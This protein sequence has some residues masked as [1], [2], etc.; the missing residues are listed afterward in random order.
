MQFSKNTKNHYKKINPKTHQTIPT[1]RM[2]LLKLSKKISKQKRTNK[3][4]P[5]LHN[6]HLDKN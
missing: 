1:K 3:D 2:T 4:Q 6:Q 5:N